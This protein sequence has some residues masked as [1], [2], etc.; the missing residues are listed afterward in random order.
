MAKL[1]TERLDGKGG[2]EPAKKFSWTPRAVNPV[3]P[4]NSSGSVPVRSLYGKPMDRMSVSALIPGGIAPFNRFP[5]SLSTCSLVRV[6]K[7]GGI[8]P[9]RP[10]SPRWISVSFVMA[11]RNEGMGPLRSRFHPNRM[12]SK[13]VNARIS[14]GRSPTKLKFTRSVQSSS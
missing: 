6:H 10:V 14:S 11:L 2:I 13:L 3:M 9:V 5:D 8:D 1:Q 12:I 7:L 4:E